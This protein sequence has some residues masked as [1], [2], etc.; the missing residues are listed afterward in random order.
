[1]TRYAR[2]I[3]YICKKKELLGR[4]K[5]RCEEYIKMDLRVTGSEDVYWTELAQD[6]IQW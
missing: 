5:H 1:M 3:A 4:P 6:K 2:H